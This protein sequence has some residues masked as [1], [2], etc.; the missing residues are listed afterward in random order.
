MPFEEQLT[1]AFDTLTERLRGEIDQEVERRTAEWIAAQ[2]PPESPAPAVVAAVPAVFDADAGS[3]ERLNDAVGAIDAARSLTEI[4][5]ALLSG[6]KALLLVFSNPA[7]QPC[8]ALLPD[9][10]RWQGD[11]ADT[12]RVA[13][14]SGGSEQAT[15]SMTDPYALEDV[16]LERERE[17][18]ERYA[19]HGTPGAVLIRSDGTIGSPV[20][21]GG[22][23]IAGL[24][25]S[26]MKPYGQL[27][28]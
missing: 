13:V 11:A 22:V 9:I 12:V 6:S 2:P 19:V 16:L 10:K 14:V 26:A 25:E 18:A 8:A 27:L 15:R 5:D 24:F 1:R 23:A 7:C 20:A 17:V 3:R 28:R 21:M 4:L